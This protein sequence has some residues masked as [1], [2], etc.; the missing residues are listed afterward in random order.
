MKYIGQRNNG[1][2]AGFELTP[3]RNLDSR[4]GGGGH[5]IVIRMMMMNTKMI[6]RMI[7]VYFRHF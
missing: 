4:E 6:G 7:T 2:L 3:T 5:E 1:V